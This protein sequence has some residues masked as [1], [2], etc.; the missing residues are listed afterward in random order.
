M[1]YRVIKRYVFSSEAQEPS[2]CL[3]LRL[4]GQVSG[5]G[6]VVILVCQIIIPPPSLDELSIRFLVSNLNTI[7]KLAGTKCYL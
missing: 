6:D 5:L 1:D 2:C 7:Y 3:L 4:R